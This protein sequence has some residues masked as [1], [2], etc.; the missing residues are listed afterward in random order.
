MDATMVDNHFIKYAH[1]FV[2][3]GFVVIISP[4]WVRVNFSTYT[5]YSCFTG[6]G[7]IVWLSIPSDVTLKDMGRMDWYTTAQKHRS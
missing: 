7:A 6:T 2:V 5:I 1:K 3:L 4:A